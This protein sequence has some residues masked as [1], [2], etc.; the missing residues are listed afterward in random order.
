[1]LARVKIIRVKLK[2]VNFENVLL[3]SSI[4]TFEKDYI[5]ISAFQQRNERCRELPPPSSL[6]S[7]F[8]LPASGCLVGL[9]RGLRICVEG[10]IRAYHCMVWRKREAKSVSQ[11]VCAT[12]LVN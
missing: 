8:A 5:L 12:G 4:Y 9:G 10:G 1:M 11:L 3:D 6:V 7:K 2:T